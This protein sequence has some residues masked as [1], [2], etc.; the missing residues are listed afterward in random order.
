MLE[1]RELTLIT[2]IDLSGTCSSTMDL[3]MGMQVITDLIIHNGFIYGRVGY[4]WPI[5]PQ[6]IHLYI[7]RLLL[8][9]SSAMDSV[10]DM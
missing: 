10:I 6:C 1:G 7:S 2:K 9:C 3:F 5:H 8:I 4:Y